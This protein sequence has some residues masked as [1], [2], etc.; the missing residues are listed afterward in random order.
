MSAKLVGY[1]AF[2]LALLASSASAQAACASLTAITNGSTADATPVWANFQAL[3]SCA[4]TVAS[5]SFTGTV[6]SSG[7]VG[8]GSSIATLSGLGKLDV[9]SSTNAS[10]MNSSGNSI[11]VVHNDTSTPTGAQVSP[12]GLVIARDKS[13]PVGNGDYLGGISWNARYDSEVRAGYANISAVA[14]GSGIAAITFNVPIT[15][16]LSPA[17]AMRV[18]Y[19]GNVGVGTANPA[20]KLHVAGTIRQTGCTTAGTLAVNSSGDII[21]SSDARLKNILGDYQDGLDAISKIKPTRF[22]YKPTKENPNEGFIHAGFIAQDVKA[23]IPQ[24]VALQQSSYYSLDTT[25]ILAATVNAIKELKAANDSQA[26]EVEKLKGQIAVLQRK[27][28]IQT[29]QR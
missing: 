9:V 7:I 8:I 11:L 19:N 14:R 26:L 13:S 10:N 29:A 23:A 4:A 6:Y 3:N 25:A 20:Q 1:G 22:S 5:P 24:A 27:L 18:D 28:G 17:E 2:L 12:T 15:T 16:A 21:C